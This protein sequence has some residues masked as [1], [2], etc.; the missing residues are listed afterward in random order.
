MKVWSTRFVMW[1]MIALMPLQ[2]MAATAAMYRCHTD[3]T[4]EAPHAMHSAD[5]QN[6]D[7]NDQDGHVHGSD[8][9]AGS[10]GGGNFCPHHFS[11]ALPTTTLSAAVPGFQVCT[12]ILQVLHDLFVPDRP[13][14]PPLA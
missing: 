5:V 3:T 10:A 1:L 11:S 9:S 2:G 14:R 7:A 8:G 12:S 4:D 13:Q 6:H